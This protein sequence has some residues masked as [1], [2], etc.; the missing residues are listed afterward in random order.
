M[1]LYIHVNGDTA[2]CPPAMKRV[3]GM[4]QPSVMVSQLQSRTSFAL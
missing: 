3:G 4:G 1:K 2:F